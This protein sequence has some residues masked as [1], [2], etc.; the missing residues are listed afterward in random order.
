MSLV[1]NY[2]I[3]YTPIRQNIPFSIPFHNSP[4]AIKREEKKT[5]CVQDVFENSKDILTTN[6]TEPGKSFAF[7]VET[8]TKWDPEAMFYEALTN[9]TSK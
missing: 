8:G 3:H 6:N 1:C 4:S 7:Y 9:I 2:N 5:Y